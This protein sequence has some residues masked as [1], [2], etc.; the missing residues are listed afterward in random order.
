MFVTRY[1]RITGIKTLSII[2]LF[3]TNPANSRCCEP[4][5]NRQSHA[6][7]WLVEFR[8]FTPHRRK[9]LWMC[10]RVSTDAALIFE[11][12]VVIHKFIIYRKL[13]CLW[14]FFHLPVVAECFC[15]TAPSSDALCLS[16]YCKMFT[17]IA[18]IVVAINVMAEIFLKVVYEFR[19]LIFLFPLWTSRPTVH[20]R[21]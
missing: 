9:R 18:C 1:D 2:S 12:R 8:F 6:T 20:I 4:L 13:R 21:R 16:S 17:L 7:V 3:T 14:T 15:L 5:T 11:R 10:T 19:T